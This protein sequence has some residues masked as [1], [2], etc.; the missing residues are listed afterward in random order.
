MREYLCYEGRRGILR[1]RT[2][3][4]PGVLSEWRVK[5]QAV[6]RGPKSGQDLDSGAQLA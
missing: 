4:V 6:L 1:I 5:A 2:H 3:L